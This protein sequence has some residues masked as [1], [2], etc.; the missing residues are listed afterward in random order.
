MKPSV[1]QTVAMATPIIAVFGLDSMPEPGVRPIADWIVANRPVA[2]VKMNTQISEIVADGR[3]NGRKNARRK[4][5]WPLFIRFVSTAKTNARITS[6]GVVYSV[7]CSVCQSEDQKS[8]RP[9]ISA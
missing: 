2:G 6:G 4:N 3:M 9:S 7:N 1:H 5:H 8:E